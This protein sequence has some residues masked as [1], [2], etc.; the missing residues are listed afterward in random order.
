L[1]PVSCFR[2]KLAAL[3]LSTFA[4]QSAQSGHEAMSLFWSLSGAKRTS[5]IKAAMSAFDHLGHRPAS[6]VAVAKPVSAHTEV[7]I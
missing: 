3:Q 6:Q 7:F 1:L 2:E 4:T 5:P